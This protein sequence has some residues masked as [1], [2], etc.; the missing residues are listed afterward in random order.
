MIEPSPEDLRNHPPAKE[1]PH[2]EEAELGLL[3][4]ILI[5]PATGMSAAERLKP[6]DFYI[7]AHRQL[8]TVILEF[9]SANEPFDFI[10]ISNT[11]RD[12]GQLDNLKGQINGQQWDGVAFITAVF[13]F[14][15]TAALSEKYAAIVAKKAKQRT[16]ITECLQLAADAEQTEDAEALSAKVSKTL[17]AIN[18]ETEKPK[19]TADEIF[20]ILDRIQLARETEGKEGVGISTGLPTLDSA[21]LHL[22]P[23]QYLVFAGAPDSG[24]SSLALTI[25]AHVSIV[26]RKDVLIFTLENSTRETL[27]KL[28][29]IR[30]GVPIKSIITGQVSQHQCDWIAQAAGEL[31]QAPLHIRDRAQVSVPEMRATSRAL[32]AKRP[33]LGLIVVDYLQLARPHDPRDSGEARLANISKE[34]KPWC[35]ELDLP[36]IGISSM[37]GDK[38]RGTAQIEYDASATVI[39]Q[40]PDDKEK[41][42]QIQTRTLCVKKRVGVEIDLRFDRLTGLWSDKRTPEPEPEEPPLL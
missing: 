23:A 6:S 30:S 18:A 9:W 26:E 19:T 21:I 37:T 10:L 4:S 31:A 25:A 13:T 14:T 34:F 40:A 39:L 7:A 5:D 17:F 32:K 1:S 15:P 2:S 8:F 41:E 3:G 35:K 38:F 36:I 11:L 20:E 24:K 27:E 12:R 42:K 29:S 22:R 16:I 33:D 28:L